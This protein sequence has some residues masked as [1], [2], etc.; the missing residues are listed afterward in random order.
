MR[1]FVGIS[2]MS[3]MALGAAVMADRP[4]QNA[5][6]LSKVLVSVEAQ[7]VTPIVEASFDDGVWEIE[8]FRGDRAVE[9]RVHPVT[10]A[11]ISERPDSSNGRPDEGSLPASEIV[12]RLEQMGYRPVLD[13]DWEHRYWEV[14]AMNQSGERELRIA[15][16]TGK[17]LSDRADD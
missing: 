1:S 9:M 5:E 15:A 11:I 17:V 2:C 7:G 4:P 12:L 6:P 3:V 16:S 10:L 13:L 14:D 8:G